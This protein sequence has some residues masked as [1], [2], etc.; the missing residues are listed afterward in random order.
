[1]LGDQRQAR[2][3][4]SEAVGLLEGSGEETREALVEALNNLGLL[5]RNAGELD[6]AV[7]YFQR[8]LSA[9]GGVSPESTRMKANISG[10]VPSS[11]LQ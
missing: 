2:S 10:T 11:C 3:C 5:S 1:M 6:L 9:V 7:D 4:L 8:A